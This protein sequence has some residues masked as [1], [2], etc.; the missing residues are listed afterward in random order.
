MT[1]VACSTVSKARDAAARLGVRRSTGDWRDLADDPA[2]DAL[3]IAVPADLQ[4]RIAERALRS[5]KHLFCE[6]PLAPEARAAAALARLAKT[7]RSVTAVDLEFPELKTWSKTRTLLNGGAI[8]SLR[9]LQVVWNVET[10]SVRHDLDSWKTS[11]ERGG[12]A[13]NAFASHTFHYVEQFAGPLDRICARLT[14]ATGLRRARGETGAAL[15]MRT[16]TGI[17]VTANVVTHAPGDPLHRLTFI[18]SKG[19]LTLENSGSDYMNGFCLTLQK[20]GSAPRRAAAEVRS[21]A[22]RRAGGTL[23]LDGRIAPAA[24]LLGRWAEAAAGRKPFSPDFA[25]GARVQTLIAA[26]RRSNAL[27]KEV[28]CG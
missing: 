25:S 20:N 18:G 9:E 22:G 13:L 23:S 7:R 3:V 10:Y 11:P 15:V 17:P 8:G 16:R 12:G 4:V 2:I 5:S 1:A 19:R 21:A 6:K 14:R 26:A 28:D 24:R 27:G